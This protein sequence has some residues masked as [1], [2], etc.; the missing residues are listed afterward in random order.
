M[1]STPSDQHRSQIRTYDRVS[2]V[3]FLKTKN[4]YGGLSNMASGFPLLVNG[5]RVRTSEALYQ[6]CRFPKLPEVQRL[7]IKQESPMTAKMKSKRYRHDSRRDWNRVRVNVMRWCLRVKLVQNWD[8]FSKLLLDTGNRPIVEQSRRDDF[9]GAKPLDERTLMGMN[10]LGRLLMELRKSVQTE[11]QQKLLRVEPLSIPDFLLWGCP[12]EPV[13]TRTLEQAKTVAGRVV[14]LRQGQ[15][16]Q[17]RENQLPLPWARGAATVP[18][19]QGSAEDAP[20]QWINFIK[21]YPNYKDSSVVWLG[22][23]PEH[24]VVTRLK[25]VARLVMGQSPPSSDCSSEPV[26][27]PFLQGCAEFGPEH[28]SPQQYSRKPAKVSPRAGI[29]MSVRAPVG[30][31]NSADQQYAIGRGLCAIIPNSRVLNSAFAYIGLEA[32]KLGLE[33]LSTGSTY[34]GVSTSD[35]GTLAVLVPPLSEQSAIVRFIRHVDRRIRRYI[36]AKQ[37]LIALLEEQKQAIIHQAVTGQIDVRT[38]LAY[39][40]YKPSGLDWLGDLPAHWEVRR[41]GRLFVQRNETGFPELPILE[42]SLN[43]GIRI[44]DFGN[45]DRKQMMAVRSEYKRAVKG[46]IAYNMMRMWQGA[47]GV[48]PVDGLVSP[49]YVVARPLKGTESSYFSILFRT[50]VYMAEVNKYSHGIVRDR[51]RLY[52]EDF[53]QMPTLYPPPDEQ[54]LIVRYIDKTT[55][56]IDSAI[57]RARRQITLLREY[58]TRLVADVVTGKLDVRGAAMCLPSEAGD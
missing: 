56:N 12:V 58:R 37:K 34:D 39:P 16:S 36:G 49:A 30:R 21:R 19:H 15:M 45:S 20:D 52:W 46:D 42:V 32:A 57:E 13:T 28:P 31:F 5:A 27:L 18:L 23:A 50:N 3:V 44:R 14:S 26:G 54:R 4:I 2:S 29:L 47:V 53:K 40:E 1:T 7:I 38:G 9:W 24:W 41:N 17:P 25:N 10:V 22:D 43:T 11:A 33:L 8:R 6:A 48:I 51:N 55:D 35:V